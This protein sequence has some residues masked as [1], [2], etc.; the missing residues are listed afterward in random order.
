MDIISKEDI[1]AP[2][3]NLFCTRK[4][5]YNMYISGVSE[6]GKSM[7]VL[8]RLSCM[9]FTPRVDTVIYL[10]PPIVDTYD[11]TGNRSLTIVDALQTICTAKGYSLIVNQSEQLPQSDGS[12][13]FMIEGISYQRGDSILYIIDD[14]GSEC[15]SCTSVKAIIERGRHVG[16]GLWIVGHK[17]FAKEDK[18][19]CQVIGSVHELVLYSHGPLRTRSIL[20][21]ILYKLGV[22][23]SKQN[24]ILHC[25]NNNKY[26][27]LQLLTSP[28]SLLLYQP[29]KVVTV[30]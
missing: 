7:H 4:F 26:V 27:F 5:P 29:D 13:F 9:S 30:I 25:F 11:N 19:Q 15:M 21:S 16:V 28:V 22:P 3:Q 17:M 12:G 6:C 8:S 24:N 2:Y 14:F 10:T 1:P 23:T 20:I 18:Y